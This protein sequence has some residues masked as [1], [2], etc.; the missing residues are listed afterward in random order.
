MA[1]VKVGFFTPEE[2]SIIRQYFGKLIHRELAAMLPQRTWDSVRKR[3]KKLGLSTPGVSYMVSIAKQRYSH[4][5]AFFATPNPLASYWAGFIAADGCIYERQKTLILNIAQQDSAHVDK[6]A[7]AIRFNGPCP[8]REQASWAQP[9]KTIRIYNATKVIKDLQEHYSITPRKS[10]TLEPPRNLDRKNSLAFIIGYIDGD[11]SIQ[12]TSQGYL[13][14]YI[15]GTELL[16]L[17]LTSYLE[18]ITANHDTGTNYPKSTVCKCESDSTHTYA[19]TGKR[20]VIIAK[21][22]LKLPV[23]RLERK[24]S[25][26]YPFI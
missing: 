11:G 3:A 7:S 22:L 26:V 19:V 23:P 1:K 8:I 9:Q 10:K 16:L 12:I 2:D 25:L 21:E 18:T 14:I 20:A 6:F 24:W 5:E 15:R 4:N 13:R 17:W